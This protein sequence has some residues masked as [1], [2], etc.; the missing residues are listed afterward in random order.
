MWVMRFRREIHVEYEVGGGPCWTWGLG[1]KSMW[2]VRFRREI[3]LR[4]GKRYNASLLERDICLALTKTGL[5]PCKNILRPLIRTRE[6]VM[7]RNPFVIRGLGEK[8]V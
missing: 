5:H 6:K 8:T 4:N 3:S 1:G 2:D 7:K